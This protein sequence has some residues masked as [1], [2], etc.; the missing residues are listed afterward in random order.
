MALALGAHRQSGYALRVRPGLEV[1]TSEL[2][3]D[4][5]PLA[6]TMPG[7]EALVASAETESA[8]EVR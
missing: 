4:A 8:C 1:R 6:Q 5:P 2:T 3:A 7:M